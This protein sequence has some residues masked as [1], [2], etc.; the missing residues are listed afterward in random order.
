MQ[1]RTIFTYGLIVLAVFLF[2][3]KMW[4]VNG[5]D[6]GTA[7][8]SFHH[9]PSPIPIDEERVVEISASESWQ[10]VGKGPVRIKS[11]GKVDLGKG[12]QTNPNDEKRPG[13]LNALAPDLPYGTLLARIGENGKPFKVGVRAQ[14]AAKENIYLAINDGDR[15]DNSG[16]YIVTL[17]GGNKY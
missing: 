3:I 12:L 10:L 17:T 2:A 7:A 9:E 16:S 14:I 6:T 4:L 8:P 11:A 15:S 5:P 1:V 13:D